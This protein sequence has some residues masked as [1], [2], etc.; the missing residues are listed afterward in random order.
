MSLSRTVIA[1][2][3][4][5]VNCESG[6][7]DHKDDDPGRRRRSIGSSSEPCRVVQIEGRDY[8]EPAFNIEFGVADDRSEVELSYCVGTFSGGCD[9]IDK[10]P[11]GGGS[12]I[13]ARVGG[14][15]D[16]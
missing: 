3:Q 16:C 10:E 8:T 12:T 9:V 11:L 7:T 5:C 2:F 14:H 4:T 6:S 13:V 1:T 15:E